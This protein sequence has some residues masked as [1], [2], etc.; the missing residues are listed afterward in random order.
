MSAPYITADM[1]VQAPTGIDWTTTV[2]GH[3]S[4]TDPVVQAEIAN[5]C[6]RATNMARAY[7]GQDLRATVDTEILEAPSFRAALQPSGICRVFLAQWPVIKVRQVQVALTY[8]C[9]W[10]TLDSSQYWVREA[11]TDTL[12]GTGAYSV[13]LAPGVVTWAYGRGAYQVSVQYVNGWP[14]ALLTQPCTAGATSLALD[15]VTGA[16]GSQLTVY[17]GANTEVVAVSASSAESGAGTVTLA[18]ATQ[19][20]HAAGVLAS[21]LPGAVQEA[22]FLLARF[23]AMT[24]GTTAVAV[25]GVRGLTAAESGGGPQKWEI[26]QAYALL[27]PYRRVI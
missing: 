2:R 27:A 10:Q 7:C 16:V 19:Y 3:T 26:A 18:A 13:E 6:W 17:D 25:P 15:E 12:D 4:L 24:R 22:C 20:G 8:P 23:Q 11:F 21:A 9:V 5:I 1:L 14:H